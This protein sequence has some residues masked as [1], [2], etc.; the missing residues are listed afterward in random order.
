MVAGDRDAE[1]A[2]RM[3][4]AEE[5]GLVPLVHHECPVL[6][7]PTHD[8]EFKRRLLDSAHVKDEL[9]IGG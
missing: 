6:W 5:K 1:K 4:I 7:I 2:F 8:E 3:E 9:D